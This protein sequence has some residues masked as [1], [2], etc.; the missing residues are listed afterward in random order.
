MNLKHLMNSQTITKW[1]ILMAA[2]GI[3]LLGFLIYLN[4]PA[5]VLAAPGDLSS[6]EAKYPNIVGT[7]LDTCTF[8]HTSP[9][10]LNPY[11]A[12]YKAAGRNPAA[13]GLIENA[14]SDG[15]GFTNLQEIMALTFP[16]DPNDHPAAPPTN[17]PT[18]TLTPFQPP[19]ATST[20]TA[21]TVPPT[22]TAVPP[23]ATRTATQP[24]V[25]TPTSTA[26]HTAIPTNTSVPGMTATPTAQSTMEVSRTPR[27]TRTPGMSPT[28]TVQCI[29]VE[30]S[31][32][33]DSVKSSTDSSRIRHHPRPCD[34]REG[35]GRRKGEDGGSNRGDGRDG[36][37]NGGN[38]SQS[39]GGLL[40]MLS[41]WVMSIFNRG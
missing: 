35:G 31:H 20:R 30:D 16:G 36:S 23:T 21:A 17:T 1:R 6:L 25:N 9:P 2:G 3:V 33:D 8:C 11:G 39:I 32:E 27:A 29:S 24:G 19:T 15:D 5:S 22:A 12:A 18:A 37:Y 14:D 26:T 28:P 13:F 10:I 40:A 38:T 4:H 34:D 41:H 7:R